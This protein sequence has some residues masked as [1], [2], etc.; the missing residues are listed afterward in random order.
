MEINW[1]VLALLGTSS[2]AIASILDKLILSSYARRAET[3]VV[4]QV[5][6]Q[7]I[8]FLPL[9]LVFGVNFIYPA[10]MLA[11]L[12][13]VVQVVPTIYYLK[14][15]QMEEVSRVSSLENLYCVFVFAGEALLF[16]VVLDLDQYLG[17]FALLAGAFLMSFKGRRGGNSFTP[18]LL[19][20]LSYWLMTAAFCVSEKALLPAL[21]ETQILIWSS[22]GNTLAALPLLCQSGIRREVHSFPGLGSAAML[23]LAMEEMMH[24]MGSILG[25]FSCSWGSATEACSVGL[26]QPLITLL[27]LLALSR[28]TP[29]LVG[30]N[31]SGSQ[32]ALK[33]SS[34]LIM[35]A[36]LILMA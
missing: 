18:C 4:L 14:A 15:V 17:G 12:A 8:L 16:G 36:G 33:L 21:P 7:Q 22:F 23:S 26:L 1:L 5:I 31:L 20:L 2:F 34:V 6:M 27:I 13:G 35:G 11:L 30:E 25:I 3:Y 10:S 19:Y 28:L 29:G 24:M 32:L 9:A